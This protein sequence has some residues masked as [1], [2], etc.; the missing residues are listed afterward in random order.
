[1]C[2]VLHTVDSNDL[3]QLMKMYSGIR[4]QIGHGGNERM[5][6]TLKAMAF[7]YI[8]TALRIYK[9]LAQGEEVRVDISKPFSYLHDPDGKGKGVLDVLSADNPTDCFPIYLSAA[10]A[11]DVCE[12]TDMSYELFVRAFTIFEENAANKEEQ[13]RMMSTMV[14]SLIATRNLPEESYET[15]ATKVC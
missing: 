3:A 13:A 7:L 11:A 9:Q 4:K 15:L 2:R 1:M 8:R 10:N 6:H 14:S 5:K 12:A